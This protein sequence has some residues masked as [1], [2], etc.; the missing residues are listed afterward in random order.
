MP[1]ASLLRKVLLA[2]LAS[3]MFE[4]LNEYFGV[5]LHQ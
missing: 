3:E 2:I 4:S 5:E 1:K